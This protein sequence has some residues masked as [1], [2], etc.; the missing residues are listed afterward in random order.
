M[1]RK[2]STKGLMLWEWQ[3][4]SSWSRASMA[5]TTLLHTHTYT[6]VNG[7]KG[8]ARIGPRVRRRSPVAVAQH[9]SAQPLG[10]VGANPVQ[11]LRSRHGVEGQLL[12]VGLTEAVLR[13]GQSFYLYEDQF[14]VVDL[15]KRVFRGG[16][17]V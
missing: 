3:A 11:L 9:V 16:E 6:Q 17:D 7:V 14:G 5:T 15:V 1:C 2:L 4:I 8:Q 13:G 12:H 10:E